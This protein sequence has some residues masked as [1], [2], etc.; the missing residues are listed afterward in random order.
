[1]QPSPGLEPS[2]VLRPWRAD[3]S[4]TELTQLLHRAYAA[5]AAEGMRFVASWQDDAV[6]GR[7]IASGQ[8]WVAVAGD[9]IVGT[10]LF[11]PPGTGSKCPYYVRPGVASFHQFAVDPPFQGRG[12]AGLLLQKAEALAVE[13]GAVELALDTAVPA[14]RLIAMYRRRGFEIVDR[15]QWPDVNYASV[16]M[17]KRVRPE[18]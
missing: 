11:R 15:M 6:T 8:A 12:I 4:V 17:S 7:R 1:M 3:D 13:A 2:I 5:P 10:V 14:T 9:R 18:P 16:V